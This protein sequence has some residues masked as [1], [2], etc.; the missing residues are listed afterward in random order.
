MS[1]RQCHVT[2]F[3]RKCSIF[4]IFLRSLSSLSSFPVIKTKIDHRQH[5][6]WWVTSNLGLLSDITFP[7][8][9]CRLSYK[10]FWT[11]YG[12]VGSAFNCHLAISSFLSFKNILAEWVVHFK[13][14]KV[15][16]NLCL[17]LCPQRLNAIAW[18]IRKYY[19]LLFP[20][21]YL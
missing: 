6:G 18:A 2:K 1:T 19:H 15:F 10:N 4:F 21:F 20:I 9:A 17:I 11:E 14:A 3:I 13:F 12:E 16:P 7:R 5:Q 8:R